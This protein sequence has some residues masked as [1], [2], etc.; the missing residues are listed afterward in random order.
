MRAKEPANVAVRC[1]TGSLDEGSLTMD[2][3]IHGKYFCSPP[4]VRSGNPLGIV[5]ASCYMLEAFLL[6]QVFCLA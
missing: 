4:E 2:T 6:R 3:G 5:I 1:L